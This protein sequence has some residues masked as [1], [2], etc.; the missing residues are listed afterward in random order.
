ML[1]VI[2]CGG[3]STRM[4][5]D[6]GLI[7]IGTQTWAASAVKKMATLDISVLVSINDQQ[8]PRYTEVFPRNQLIPDDPAISLKGPLLKGAQLKGSQ[9]KG[10]LAG[11][12]SVHILAPTED[13]F[14]LACDLPLMDPALLK[15]LYLRQQQ[16]TANAY[17]YTADGEPEPLCGIYKAS[18]LALITGLYRAGKLVRHSMKYALDQLTVDSQPIPQDKRQC[19]QNF[20]YPFDELV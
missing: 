13:L 12:L 6:K 18:G 8:L 9:L 4:G 17:L 16:L 19:F 20:N 2:L 15:N 1:G 3:D 11:I 5:E 14:V 7:P 10:P